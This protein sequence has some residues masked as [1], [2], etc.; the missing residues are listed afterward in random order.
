MHVDRVWA[1]EGCNGID[2]QIARR[3]VQDGET[4]LDVPT[5]LSAQ[6]R[7][8]A[9][10]NDRKTDPGMRDAAARPSRVTE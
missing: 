2:K 8:F 4:V 3:P 10:G 5:N 9:S 1:V 6:V 7:V